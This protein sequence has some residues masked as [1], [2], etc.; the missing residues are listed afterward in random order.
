MR[1][2]SAEHVALH[3]TLRRAAGGRGP[4][5]PPPS[6]VTLH[7]TLATGGRQ[8]H[9]T[10]HPMLLL[11]HALLLLLLLRHPMLSAMLLSGMTGAQLI[12]QGQ[13]E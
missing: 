9:A 13:L 6:G 8:G 1:L 7:G 11:P 12:R 2:L 3:G 5:L 4:A 10:P